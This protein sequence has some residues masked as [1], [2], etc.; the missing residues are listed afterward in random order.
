LPGFD[1][2]IILAVAAVAAGRRIAG[3]VPTCTGF[4]ALRG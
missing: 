4:D 2:A 1:V 3:V